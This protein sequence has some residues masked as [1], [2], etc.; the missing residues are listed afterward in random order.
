MK[1]VV[2]TA[3]AGATVDAGGTDGSRFDEINI[4]AG[5]HLTNV[6][7][8]IEVGSGK[9]K[10][11]LTFDENSIGRGKGTPEQ[12][13]ISTTGGDLN[14]YNTVEEDEEG[15]EE[16]PRA[17]DAFS[18]DVTA[19]A[20]IDMVTEHRAEGVAS[21]LHAVTDGVISFKGLSDEAL[22]TLLR[23]G[24]YTG[25]LCD[26]GWTL[27]VDGGDLTLLGSSAE[28]YLVLKDE[29]DPRGDK[30]TVA[31]DEDAKTL[32]GKRATLLDSGTTLT[33]DMSGLT[34]KDKKGVN[35]N[36]N[37]LVGLSGST[38]RAT[39]SGTVNL[40]NV[41]WEEGVANEDK[42]WLGDEGFD[43][44]T[45]ESL[46]GQN[47]D[48]YGRIVGENGANF[49][50]KGAGTLT[51][52]DGTFK[53]LAIDGDLKLSGGDF[54]VRSG[55]GE[56]SSTLGSLTFA[57]GKDATVGD[58]FVVKGGRIEVGAIVEEAGSKERPID[59]SKN[60]VTL[61]DGGIFAF[62]GKMAEADEEAE[63]PEETLTSTKFGGAGTLEIGGEEGEDGARL[64]LGSGYGTN[65][66]IGGDLNVQLGSNGILKLKDGATMD[67]GEV[68]LAGTLDMSAMAA[69]GT[70]QSL[71]GDGTLKGSEINTK[72]TIDG[73]PG[74]EAKAFGGTLEGGGTLTVGSGAEWRIKG[75]QTKP[76]DEKDGKWNLE[77]A[78]NGTLDVT[79]Q[80]GRV[81]YLGDVTLGDN[82]T[83]FYHYNNEAG[84]DARTLLTGEL[85][86]ADENTKANLKVD[87]TN[88]VP[89]RDGVTDLTLGGLKWTNKD[90][91]LEDHLSV[92]LEGAGKQYFTPSAKIDDDS[93]VYVD[94]THTTKNLYRHADQEKN[95]AAGAELF[96]GVDDPLTPLGK[97]LR[98]RQK[99]GEW[100]DLYKFATAL[101]S[102]YEGK[103]IDSMLA[104]G[105]G[106]SI[107]TLG[108]ALGDDL[109]RQ[110]NSIRNRTTVMGA[111]ARYDQYDVLPLYHMW[112]N[113]ETGYHKLDSDGLAPGYTLNS[114][115]GT[116][117]LEMDVTRN[118]T[119]GLALSAMYG[120]LKTEAAD[121]GSGD[122]DTTY[123]SAFMSARRGAW[124]H[125]VVL[126]GGMADVKFN[127][128]VGYSTST[129]FGAMPGSYKTSGSTDGYAVGALYEIGYTRMANAAGTVAVQ[130]VFNVEYRR[131]GINGYTEAGS[132]AA[133]RV[134]DI[135]QD[136]IT[137]GAGARV[138]ALTGGN[139]FN[140]SAIFEGRALLKVEA[141]DRS[142]K[143]IN[144]IVNTQK[145]AELES[146][147][148]GAVGV[149]VGAGITIPL[150]STEGSIFIDGSLELRSGYTSMDATVG[151]RVSF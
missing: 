107:S 54:V 69:P 88:F 45:L 101:G 100:T 143:A 114:W 150:G 39:G 138:Q 11:A 34:D 1:L 63:T 99:D 121:S 105:A 85:K 133:L 72:L 91:R 112:V 58:G 26:L 81:A 5:G 60:K 136:S 57:Y 113:G 123:M 120:D 128:T 43:D 50:K 118:V 97:D 141:G 94:F 127:R 55:A 67:A 21:Y 75:L 30:A 119:V 31:S 51:V 2:D 108:Q 22:N 80:R 29:D 106:A 98:D 59:A 145:T 8:N 129:I 25:W 48:F 149:E 14:V 86:V 132:D 77:V 78:P 79:L 144:A 27:G 130:P 9:T 66:A 32:G 7:G 93:V 74:D 147:E 41:R 125:T 10:M 62:T 135:T 109:H 126:S 18:L 104:A 3:A 96:W 142:G 148:V 36:V 124:R 70:A 87:M 103:N 110:I 42:K 65:A 82:S 140:R 61:A 13:L 6:N 38:L 24:N 15:S 90:L 52:G 68:A 146:A 44:K 19:E 4:N 102:Q 46:K 33:L 111:E 139:V 92:T 53:A 47:T 23:S 17:N 84:H 89:G 95:A 40:N 116:L 122:L 115:G 73:T 16:D 20:L 117:G 76:G 37:N 56:Y 12:Y 137:F 28:V 35:V 83:L 131:V 64:V 151:Y 71:I 49:N 134:D